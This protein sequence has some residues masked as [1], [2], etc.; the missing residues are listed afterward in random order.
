MAVQKGGRFV[1]VRDCMYKGK[2]VPSGKVVELGPD[3][4]M[5]NKAFV[6]STDENTN[7]QRTIFDPTSKLAT[8][9]R[10]ANATVGLSGR[11]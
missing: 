7:S 6:R 5:K 10:V 2:F 3:E 1:A 8:V 11:N 9:R 4:E